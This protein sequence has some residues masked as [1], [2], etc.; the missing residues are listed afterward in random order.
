[1][2][3][4]AADQPAGDTHARL[5][6]NPRRRRAPG[7]RAHG[8][9]GSRRRRRQRGPPRS[10]RRARAA[11]DAR[12]HAAVVHPL[13]LVRPGHRDHRGATAGGADADA[14]RCRPDRAGPG[15]RRGH[16]RGARDLDRLPRPRDADG[17][18]VGVAPWSAMGAAAAAGPGPG[19]AAGRSVAA[20]A[21]R[22]RR[23]ILETSRRPGRDRPRREP[24]VARP[25]RPFPA[26]ARGRPRSRHR[27][28]RCAQ[29]AAG[30][31]RRVAPRQAELHR[32]RG[33]I[34]APPRRPGGRGATLHQRLV[35]EQLDP[36][37][38]G[39]PD[40]RSA[41]ARPGGDQ[42][43]RPARHRGDLAGVRPQRGLVDLGPGGQSLPGRGVRFRPGLRRFRPYRRRSN[44]CGRP[45][46]PCWRAS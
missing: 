39:D 30:E 7:F 5:A 17:R 6:E 37:E 32:P 9:D 3:P 23:R 29:R 45:A 1:M 14:A 28:A 22:G 44:P 11:G 16:G 2:H 25:S 24:A 13:R 15:D 41:A 31:H 33:A 43:H 34:H 20:R 12:G 27:T 35:G 18:L 19:P 46:A 8:A 40:D 10:A 42:R 36:A 4:L 38:H 26:G 21:R